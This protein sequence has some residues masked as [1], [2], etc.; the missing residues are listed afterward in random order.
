MS[1]SNLMLQYR[2]RKASVEEI[3]QESLTHMIEDNIR[4]GKKRIPEVPFGFIHEKWNQFKSHIQDGDELWY[5]NHQWGPLNG[6]GGWLLVR[7]DSVGVEN[8]VAMLAT[9]VS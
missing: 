6:W 4:T 1:R 9:R 7:K 3:E 2:S 5:A 8:V